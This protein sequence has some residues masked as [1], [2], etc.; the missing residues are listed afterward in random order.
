MQNVVRL[1]SLIAVDAS[2]LDISLRLF[3]DRKIIWLYLF[4]PAILHKV[5]GP[6]CIECIDMP[7]GPQTSPCRNTGVTD[8]RIVQSAWIVIKRFEELE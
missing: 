2:F 6:G 7:Q 1:G 4:E 8:N 5:T 3:E